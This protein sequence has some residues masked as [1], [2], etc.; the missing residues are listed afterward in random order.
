MQYDRITRLLHLLIA[1]GVCVQLLVSE[2]MEEPESDHLADLFYGVHEYLGIALFGLSSLY[3]LW[4][5][6]RKSETHLT[7]FFPWMSPSRYQPILEDVKRYIKSMLSLSLP[8]SNLPNPL[9]KAVQGAGLVVALMLGASGLL[10]YLYAPPGG[11]LRGWLHLVEEVHEVFGGLLWIYL[12]AHLSMAVL[13]QLVGHSRIRDM[14][15]FWKKP[16]DY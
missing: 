5:A 7:Q 4:A 8:D 3:C 16:G 11:E 10:I 6:I 14:F 13:H 15:L 1:A 9:A 12:V 2:I